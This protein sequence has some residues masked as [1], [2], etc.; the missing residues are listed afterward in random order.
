MA[1]VQMARGAG[2]RGFDCC[3]G[4]RTV[5]AHIPRA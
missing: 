1:V 5:I 2:K 4:K 3:L